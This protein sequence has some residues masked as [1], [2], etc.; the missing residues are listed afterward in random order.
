M[1]ENDRETLSRLKEG[2]IS[3]SHETFIHV[4]ED[5]KD[6]LSKLLIIDPTKRMDVKKALEHRWISGDSIKHREDKLPC[7]DSLSDYLKKWRSWVSII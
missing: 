2:K 3:F 7:I 5:A 4:S 1:G 6:F